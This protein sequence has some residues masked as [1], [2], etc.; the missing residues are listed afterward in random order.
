MAGFSSTE[1]FPLNRNIFTDEDFLAASVTDRPAADISE[2]QL[3]P[4]LHCIGMEDA[5]ACSVEEYLH[6]QFDHAI[7][8]DDSSSSG[9]P[10]EAVCQSSASIRPLHLLKSFVR[11][12]LPMLSVYQLK[13]FII[14]VLEQLRLVRYLLSFS[15]SRLHLLLTK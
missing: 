6:D 1:I 7:P 2:N 13:R 10:T 15:S 9:P 14:A 3:Y 8:Q 12:V 4:T 11:P 5:S